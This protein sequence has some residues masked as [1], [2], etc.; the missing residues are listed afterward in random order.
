ME[1]KIL[2]QHDIREWIE[3]SLEN[4]IMIPIWGHFPDENLDIYIKS[5]IIDTNDA[6]ATARY[7]Y[8]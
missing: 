5:Y 8:I 3:T 7:K 1:D 2:Y 6:K 4:E